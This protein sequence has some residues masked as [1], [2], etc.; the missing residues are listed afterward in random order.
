M[1]A[2]LQKTAADL[3][4]VADEFLAHYGWVTRN[5]I[6]TVVYEDTGAYPLTDPVVC[7][8]STPPTGKS[9]DHDSDGSNQDDPSV[10]AHPDGTVRPGS[11]GG[12]EGGSP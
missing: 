1:V 11:V 10:Q 6:A 2:N 12:A 8:V 3:G 7:G 4:F 5:Q 9:P